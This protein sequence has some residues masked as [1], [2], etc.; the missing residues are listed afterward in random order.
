M[1]ISK[2]SLKGHRFTDVAAAPVLSREVRHFDDGRELP[3]SVSVETAT[4]RFRVALS[5]DEA[6]QIAKDVA[7]FEARGQ[8][9]LQFGGAQS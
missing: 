6:R 8:V 2:R 1:I 4:H 7:E 3:F 5:L 9:P